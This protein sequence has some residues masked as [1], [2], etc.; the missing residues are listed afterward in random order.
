MFWSGF[1]IEFKECEE[2]KRKQT[3][4][5]KKAVKIPSD[6]EAVNM[7][8]SLSKNEIEDHHKVKTLEEETNVQTP[9]K[10]EQGRFEDIGIQEFDTCK[11]YVVKDKE[12]G[13]SQE[14]NPSHNEFLIPTESS[15]KHIKVY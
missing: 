10:I 7:S 4:T 13:V 6:T 14:L 11:K 8:K 9:T 1:K 2:S 12:I 3:S 15:S 5:R